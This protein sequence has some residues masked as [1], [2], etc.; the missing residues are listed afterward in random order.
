MDKTSHYSRN[1]ATQWVALALI[2]LS[3]SGC[4]IRGAIPAAQ[5]PEALRADARE[6]LIPIDL[7]L[8]GQTRPQD[9][10][11]GPRDVLGIYIE[12]VFGVRDQLPP[13]N[14]PPYSGQPRIVSEPAI[15]QPVEVNTD[16]TIFLPMI[17]PVFVTG[18]TV[19]EVRQRLRQIYVDQRKV[20][21]AGQERI[22]VS[23]IRPRTTRVIVIRD[24]LAAVAATVTTDQNRLIAGRGSAETLELPIYENDLIHALARTGGLPGLDGGDEVWLFRAANEA[25]SLA[26]SERFRLGESAEMVAEECGCQSR[27]KRIPLKVAPETLPDF[28]PSDVLLGEGD[29]VYVRRRDQDY[30]LT[31]G[32][33]PGAKIPLPKDHD[34]DVLEAIAIVNGH[35]DGPTQTTNNFVNGPGNIIP[36]SRV[37]VVRRWGRDQQ[38]KIEVDI[39]RALDDPQERILVQPGDLLILKYSPCETFLNAGMNLVNF[40]YIL[41]QN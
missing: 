12:D 19:T 10:I 13:H 3:A 34:V 29:V 40:S 30:F 28:T 26:V 24:D 38:I 33:L 31:G 8:L 9:H 11:I 20:L 23:L 2:A 14:Y 1:I 36:P 7:S 15:G 17:D 22:S 41:N 18:L 5:L 27:I 32:L 21:R 4:A 6:T 39:R 37:L 25:Q 35:V 16:G